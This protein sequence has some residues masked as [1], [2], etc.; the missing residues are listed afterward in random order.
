MHAGYAVRTYPRLCVA[1]QVVLVHDVEVD[2]QE[3]LIAAAAAPLMVPSEPLAMC[4]CHVLH[5]LQSNACVACIGAMLL[6]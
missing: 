4:M 1:P 6:G 2:V 5:I 3:A